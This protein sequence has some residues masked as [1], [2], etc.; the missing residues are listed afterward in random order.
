MLA[1]GGGGVTGNIFVG[2]SRKGDFDEKVTSKG[3]PGE[4]GL[5]SKGQSW[6]KPSKQRGQKPPRG[7]HPLPAQWSL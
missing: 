4:N 1:D 7:R 2:I 6:R 3:K 5:L